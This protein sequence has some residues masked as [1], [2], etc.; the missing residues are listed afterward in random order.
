METNEC[1]K[2]QWKIE[3][4]WFSLVWFDGYSIWFGLIGYSIPNLVYTYILHIYDL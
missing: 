1:I 3:I 2:I 4:I